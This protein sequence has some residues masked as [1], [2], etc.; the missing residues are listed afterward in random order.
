MDANDGS[1]PNERALA[2]PLVLRDPRT[3]AAEPM[4]E[5]NRAIMGASLAEI[6]RR[7][8]VDV[9]GEIA[10]TLAFTDVLQL[11][12]LVARSRAERAA[13]PPKPSWSATVGGD[14]PMEERSFLMA[15]LALQSL[16]Q[17]RTSMAEQNAAL[18]RRNAKL[19][20][21]LAGYSERLRS[22][23]K[24]SKRVLLQELEEQDDILNAHHRLLRY[25]DPAAAR[26]A[27]SLLPE[28]GAGSDGD[29]E[30]EEE[31][32]LGTPLGSGGGVGGG[33]ENVD[34]G[35]SSSR[36]RPLRERRR[37]AGDEDDDDDPAQMRT[38]RFAAGE[39]EEAFAAAAA[40][41]AAAAAVAAVAAY[42]DAAA[43]ATTAPAAEEGSSAG[44]WRGEES[45]IH[46]ASDDS[47]VIVD[48]IDDVSGLG[49]DAS[50]DGGASFSTSAAEGNVHIGVELAP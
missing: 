28:G 7:T 12:P 24:G 8:N 22:E 27:A 46:S 29:G 9:L 21:K 23:R 33:D 36:P 13:A 43:T 5:A 49:L 39:A 35:N 1:R 34:A 38:V 40:V 47:R 26:K 20:R 2:P 44:E 25:L 41:A 45:T 16:V 15:Q 10:E 19:E 6:I 11:V 50:R 32:A 18:E 48:S 3:M 42:A 14:E 17:A 31:E 4:S 30:E 37:E